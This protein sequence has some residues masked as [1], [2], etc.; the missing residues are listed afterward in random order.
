VP[1]I[2]DLPQGRFS[3]EMSPA[4]AARTSGEGK[5]YTQAR[6][7]GIGQSPQAE[8]ASRTCAGRNRTIRN[9]AICIRINY[10]ATCEA[11]SCNLPP[12]LEIRLCGG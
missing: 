10:D 9:I 5:C 1:P 3:T 6:E 11:T 4:S 2:C 8:A 7:L 12:D